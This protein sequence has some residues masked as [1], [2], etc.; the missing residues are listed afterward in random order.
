MCSTRFVREW[1][2]KEVEVQPSSLFFYAC[3][4]L[5]FLTNIAKE[6]YRFSRSIIYTSFQMEERSFMLLLHAILPF[7]LCAFTSSLASFF[8]L[9]IHKKYPLFPWEGEHDCR[10]LDC[11][12]FS[13]WA[14]QVDQTM[15]SESSRPKRNWIHVTVKNP[16]VLRVLFRWSTPSLPA[17]L[18]WS[19][20]SRESLLFLFLGNNF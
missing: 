4:F 20:A 7:I 10:R 18:F 1:V 11:I 19:F 15:S 9:V 12:L 6:W 17:I 3:S 14:D 16:L 2:V 13:P 5:L 8:L